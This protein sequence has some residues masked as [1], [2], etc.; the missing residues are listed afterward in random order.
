M[1]NNVGEEINERKEKENETTTT[2]LCWAAAIELWNLL[3]AI[4]FR[5]SR[6]L[7]FA[8]LHSLIYSFSFHLSQTVPDIPDRHNGGITTRRNNFSSPACFALLFFVYFFVC[9]CCCL[10]IESNLL[11]SASTVNIAAGEEKKKQRLKFNIDDDFDVFSRWS[12]RSSNS[13]II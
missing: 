8:S 4:S 9:C 1:L 5:P 13:K 12:L 7:L 6:L 2:F 10:I 3:L 11:F